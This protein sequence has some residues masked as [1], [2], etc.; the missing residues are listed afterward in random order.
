MSDSGAQLFPRR[1]GVFRALQLGDLLCAVPAL[2]AIRGR[3]PDARITLIGLPWTRAFVDRFA[4]YV[5]DLISFPGFPGLPEA[6]FD[7]VQ[8]IPFLK[9]AKLRNF[10]LLIQMHGAGS[11]TNPLC[12]LLGAERLAGFFTPGQF[13]PDPELFIP[14]PQN[15]P[16]I[17]RPLRLLQKLQIPL[18]GDS[19]EFPMSEADR[20]AVELKPGT[21]VCLHPGARA[22]HRRW[23][24]TEFAALGDALASW[25][26]RIVITGS[27]DERELAQSL[28][29]ALSPSA[30]SAAMDLSGQTSLGTLAW[31][32]KNARL[33]VCNDTGVSHLACALRV[34][35][36]VIFTFPESIGWPPLDRHRHR[37][38]SSVESITAPR[39]LA[40][41]ED[42]LAKESRFGP[43]LTASLTK[44]TLP[45]AA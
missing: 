24:I 3:F 36:V 25:G 13:C 19:L 21:Y 5:D 11:L 42:L 18:R 26:V 1:I 20:P 38:V 8:F 34:P 44:G 43:L 33:L 29:S 28:L 16:E 10:D 4:H 23:E 7:S 14:Y 37:V 22:R 27:P 6:P 32:L 39:V 45:F 17:R 9:E 31:L 40:E 30:R 41:I 2:R 35:S 12:S 15:E